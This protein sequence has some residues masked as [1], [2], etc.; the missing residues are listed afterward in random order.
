MKKMAPLF[1]ETAMDKRPEFSG[2]PDPD[3]FT[4]RDLSSIGQGA[5]C[6]I[7]TD[8]STILQLGSRGFPLWVDLSVNTRDRSI[9]PGA[10]QTGVLAPG[11]PTTAN[12]RRLAGGLDVA[13]GAPNDALAVIGPAR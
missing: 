2:F 8:S 9:E 12:R 6:L 7:P 3:L 4:S 11:G 1:G 10:A 13:I 5:P